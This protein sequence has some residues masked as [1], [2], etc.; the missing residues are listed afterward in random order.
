MTMKPHKPLANPLQSFQGHWQ[1]LSDDVG[2]KPKVKGLV[3]LC[4][5]GNTCF[6][7]SVL[8]CLFQSGPF[9]SYFLE[10]RYQKDINMSNPL[11][12]N[13]DVAN[14]WAA[15]TEKIWGDQYKTVAPKDFKKEIGKVAPRFDGYQQQD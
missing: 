2:G 3:G 10:K 8:Q 13:G 9:R 7:N 6:M 14:T 5:L 1:R 12:W 11:G 15:L 4:N